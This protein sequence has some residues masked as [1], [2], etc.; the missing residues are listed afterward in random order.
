M[1][2]IKIIV[3][4]ITGLFLL[5]LVVTAVLPQ[6]T[7]TTFGVLETA[8]TN[9]DAGV[10][11][12]ITGHY[13]YYTTITN[14]IFAIMIIG[15]IATGFVLAVYSKR[16]RPPYQGYEQLLENQNRPRGGLF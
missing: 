16:E 9:E 4:S 2:I 10:G 7:G 15:V 11:E 5:Y 12:N 14:V 6:I 13:N 1:N 8:A 3:S